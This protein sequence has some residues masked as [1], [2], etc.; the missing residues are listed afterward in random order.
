[1]ISAGDAPLII[2][3]TYHPDED[4]VRRLRRD[5]AGQRLPRPDAELQGQD[6]QVEPAGRPRHAAPGRR[7]V[8]PAARPARGRRGWTTRSRCAPTSCSKL[9]LAVP[10]TWDDLYTVLKAMKAA[11]PRLVPVLRPVEHAAQPGREQPAEHPR[12]GLRHSGPAGATSHATWDP[13]ASKFVYTGATDQYK[14][15]LA[16]PQQAGDREAARPGE[17]HP[18]RR[19]GP[20]EARHRQVLR[21][22]LQRADPG[23]RLPPGHRQ[24]PRRQAREDPAADRAAGRRSSRAAGWRTAS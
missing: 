11:L 12:R 19:P 4:A 14:Q 15:M 13:A 2:P 23:Q 9:N 7:Q 10:K 3:K 21:H 16:V 17:L 24:D 8:L 20:A 1:M 22:Q 5:P 6:R 18:D